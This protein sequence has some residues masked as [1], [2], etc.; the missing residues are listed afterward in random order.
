MR[1]KRR[2]KRKIDQGIEI[3]RIIEKVRK[4]QK[5]WK[6]GLKFFKANYESVFK[7]KFFKECYEY[8]LKQFNSTYRAK[9]E[10]VK[11]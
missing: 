3:E 6:V 1:K 7:H 5:H 4:Y 10:W 11:K 2:A 8:F 9:S